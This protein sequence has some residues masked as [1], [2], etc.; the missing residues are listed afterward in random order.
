MSRNEEVLKDFV[1]YC[2]QHPSERFW[3]ALRNWAG[4]YN[5]IYASNSIEAKD[6]RLVVDTFYWEG[7][8]K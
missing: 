5:F 6:Q 7:K 2:S 8:N 4:D 3:Q 1:N